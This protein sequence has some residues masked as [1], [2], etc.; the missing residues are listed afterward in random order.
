M[1]TYLFSL[2]FLFSALFMSLN[3][4]LSLGG[5]LLAQTILV[6]L[7]SGYFYYNFWFSYTLFLIMIGGML[8]MFIYMTSVA[9]NEKF[10]SPKLM[11][12]MM[13]IMMVTFLIIM[14]LLMDNF[15]SL[16]MTLKLSQKHTLMNMSL[17]KYFMLPQM[18]MMLYLILYLLMTLIIVV[19]IV[20]KNFGTLR[21][22]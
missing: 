16:S 18:N 11:I 14:Y 5:T 20:G 3:H 8:V 13:A 6:S 7:M 17:N 22:K 12:T 15:M 21:Q 9:S 4:P 19:K 10:K 1:L 2:N